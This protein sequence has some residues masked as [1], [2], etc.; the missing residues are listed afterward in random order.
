MGDGWEE[1]CFFANRSLFAL[2]LISAL[3]VLGDSSVK[4]GDNTFLYPILRGISSSYLWNAVDRSLI[5]D[6]LGKLF[7]SLWVPFI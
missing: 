4:C 1:I 5:P 3:F 6:L 7:F 2:F